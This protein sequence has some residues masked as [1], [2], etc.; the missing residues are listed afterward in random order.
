MSPKLA[1]AALC[2]VKKSEPTRGDIHVDVPLGR[3]RRRRRRRVR[4]DAI[5]K[6]ALQ[7][8]AVDPQA[9]VV[10][11]LRLP[12]PR[13]GQRVT[14]AA[15]LPIMGASRQKQILYCVALEP[16]VVDLHGD[17]MTAEGVEYTAHLYMERLRRLSRPLRS[18][19]GQG[20]DA[21]VVES[22]IAPQ[23][24]TFETGT[25][26]PQT[27]KKGS[28]VVAIKVRDPAEWAKVLSGEYTGVSVGGRGLRRPL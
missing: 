21:E 6:A 7:H 8:G 3:A 28:W 13:T 20:V 11:L 23:D 2:R 17:I 25:Y 18:M 12:A 15:G 16:D 9:L 5:A 1:R 22:Y 19:H 24:L 4:L 10:K 26:G 27:V 14:K